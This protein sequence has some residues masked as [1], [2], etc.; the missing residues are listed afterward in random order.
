MCLWYRETY[1]KGWPNDLH[2]AGETTSSYGKR[3]ACDC[4]AG[5][6]SGYVELAAWMAN[7]INVYVLC[8][9][10][11]SNLAWTPLAGLKWDELNAISHFIQTNCVAKGRRFRSKRLS[12]ENNIRENKEHTSQSKSLRCTCQDTQGQTNFTFLKRTPQ[13]ATRFQNGRHVF[14]VTSILTSR[15]PNQRPRLLIDSWP[16]KN[17]ITCLLLCEY[18]RRQRWSNRTIYEPAHAKT[19][20]HVREKT[21]R[22]TVW[23]T[24]EVV[25]IKLTAFTWPRPV[26]LDTFE[27]T[28]WNVRCRH[29]KLSSTQTL[30]G[31]SYTRAKAPLTCY[32]SW[33]LLWRAVYRY[34][35]Q[36]V[37]RVWVILRPRSQFIWRTI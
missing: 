30:C 14:E 25:S 2:K 27:L 1:K 28:F 15:R 35:F 18:S 12:S 24:C 13:T 33:W 26:C 8:T 9:Y 21:R 31:G 7:G 36:D 23:I 11:V 3:R 37:S 10:L 17:C 34:V 19:S 29:C 16:P 4:A 5:T 22:E 20:C 32:C 6:R